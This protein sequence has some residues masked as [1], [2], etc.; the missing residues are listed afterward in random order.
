MKVRLR[1][2]FTACTAADPTTGVGVV[3]IPGAQL[4]FAEIG[5]QPGPFMRAHSWAFDT[6]DIPAKPGRRRKVEA[7][8]A[9]P[10]EE[11]DR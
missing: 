1:E 6:R 8:T 11:R 2:D 5:I 3:L 10:G 4:D 9:A 7:A